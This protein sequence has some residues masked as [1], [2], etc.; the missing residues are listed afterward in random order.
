M[1]VLIQK[2]RQRIEAQL[3]KVNKQQQLVI[4]FG[5]DHE[6]RQLESEK[7]HWNRRLAELPQEREPRRIREHYVVKARRIE[8]VGLVYLGLSADERRPPDPRA[9]GLAGLSSAAGAGCCPA[10]LS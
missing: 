7:K 4:D 3:K 1:E 2:Q 6:K 8:L 10:C 9:P 5:D